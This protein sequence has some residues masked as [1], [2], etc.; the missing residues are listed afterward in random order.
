M[1]PFHFLVVFLALTGVLYAQE[2]PYGTAGGGTLNRALHAQSIAAT[3]VPV[4][5]SACGT[6]DV[7]GVLTPGEWDN[8]ASQAITVNTA[9]GPQLATLYMMHDNLTMYFAIRFP[10]TGF[11]A[12]SLG[13]EFDKD[14][15]GVPFEAGD[16]AI[17]YNNQAGFF[18]DFRQPCGPD[19]CAPEDVSDGGS[20]QGRGAYHNDGVSSVYELA[21]P[22][23]GIDFA[24]DLACAPG[25]VPCGPF[26]FFILLRIIDSGTIYDTYYPGP[27]VYDQINLDE[28]A[29]PGLSGCGTPTID[30]NIHAAEWSGA[31]RA[32][33]SVFSN[34]VLDT[35]SATLY[36]MNDS[37]NLYLGLAFDQAALPAGS[38]LRAMFDNSSL[39]GWVGD[40]LVIFDQSRGLLDF[41]A[42]PCPPPPFGSPPCYARDINVGGTN[43]GS[44]AVANDGVRTAY[45]TSHPF[46][47][48]DPN[49]LGLAYGDT[50]PYHLDLTSAG[51]VLFTRIPSGRAQFWANWTTP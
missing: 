48:S 11:H 19:M 30:G 22:F 15:D 5:W 43:D 2:T 4:V 24:H 16:D 27:A 50:V 10:E 51:G 13:I 14:N 1:K 26:G 38:Q 33:L 42:V 29:L 44:M 31:G 17:V 41:V 21:H 34:S 35:A 7:D 36:L 28:C 37:F 46:N 20:T 8:A 45:E 47:G 3:R 23:S 18:D 32:R 6:A 39:A 25:I 49:D 40:D 9:A 12:G